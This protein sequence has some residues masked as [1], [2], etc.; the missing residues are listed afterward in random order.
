MPKPLPV[1]ER[2]A[3]S[4][5]RAPVAASSLRAPGRGRGCSQPDRFASLPSGCSPQRAGARD[6]RRR[7][8]RSLPAPLRRRQPRRGSQPDQPAR[9]PARK[10]WGRVWS[11][12]RAPLLRACAK[13]RHRGMIVRPEQDPRQDRRQDH[14]E[15]DQ[16]AIRS[17]LSHR[18]AQPHAGRNHR[19][20]TGSQSVGRASSRFP[21]SSNY[22]TEMG[23]RKWQARS[24]ALGIDAAHPP[25]STMSKVASLES[26]SSSGGGDNS[27]AMS[28][29]L[30]SALLSRRSVSL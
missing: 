18:S 26:G 17:L 15:T 16:Q 28:S 22:F 7:V 4:D 14:A 29:S 5:A 2:P 8:R 24:I 3:L 30:R 13:H 1:C 9:Q 25:N 20:H 6:W 10:R 19:R 23:G 21:P 12:K 27:L 11:P